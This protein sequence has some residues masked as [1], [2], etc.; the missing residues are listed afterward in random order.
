MSLSPACSSGSDDVSAALFVCSVCKRREE[1]C[2]CEAAE[3]WTVV[4]NLRAK[5]PSQAQDGAPPDPP[6]KVPD[7]K[8]DDKELL[9]QTLQIVKEQAECI[10][11]IVKKLPSAQDV[12]KRTVNAALDPKAAEV[13]LCDTEAQRT[14]SQGSD[15]ETGKKHVQRKRIDGKKKVDVDVARLLGC[16]PVVGKCLHDKAVKVFRNQ[17]GQGVKCSYCNA[18]VFERASGERVFTLSD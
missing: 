16:M 13:N 8:A 4:E 10:Q 18:R 15:V 12:D 7:D 3:F 9:K 11:Q 1:E 6:A 17:Y 5:C 2:G 14:V